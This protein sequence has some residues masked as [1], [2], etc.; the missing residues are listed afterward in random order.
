[1]RQNMKTRGGNSLGGNYSQTW[2]RNCGIKDVK[3][4]LATAF[5]SYR[6][7][8]MTN[9]DERDIAATAL[10]SLAPY[11]THHGPVHSPRLQSLFSTFM[12]TYILCLKE[13]QTSLRISDIS[14]TEQNV[15]RPSYV[16]LAVWASILGC[17]KTCIQCQP[18]PPF[19]H[20][21]IS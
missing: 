16:S 5:C 10:A 1:M 13:N 14:N 3:H 2:G 9:V 21:L 6:T 15:N 12:P 7:R 20:V 11:V 18:F 17:F 19:N 8:Q 4:S